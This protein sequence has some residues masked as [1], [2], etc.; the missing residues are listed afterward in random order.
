LTRSTARLAACWR[1]WAGALGFALLAGCAGTPPPDWALDAKAAVDAAV[2]ADL[3]GAARV[4]TLEFQRARTALARSGRL[5][6]AARAELL[7]CAARVASLE[8]GPCP[9]FDAL[10]VDA[11]AG[12]RAYARYLAGSAT[13]DD[14]A[15]LPAHHRAVATG[16]GADAAV[17]EGVEDP[18]A[19]LVGAAVMLQA[20]RASPDVVALDL[21]CTAQMPPSFVEYALRDGAAA[22]VVSACGEGACVFRLGQ[23]WTA[24]RL[25]GTREPHLRSSVP[26]DRMATVWA[27]AGDAP[28]VRAALDALRQRLAGS[29]ASTAASQSLHA[30]G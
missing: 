15:L 20:A 22:V 13:A 12:D 29:A 9:A 24:A 6:L 17:L 27:D 25:A 18:L 7:R 11:T 23:R 16:R 19:R 21:P 2:R 8:L 3:Q 4:Q 28:K 30:H 5:D 14:V 26:R 1:R 10:A